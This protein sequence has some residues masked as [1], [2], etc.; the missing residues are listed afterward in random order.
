MLLAR[1]APGDVERARELV[2]AALAVAQA[3]G[4]KMLIARL[5]PLL[6]ACETLITRP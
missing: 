1:R 5:E 4:I 6:D 3:A 2:T